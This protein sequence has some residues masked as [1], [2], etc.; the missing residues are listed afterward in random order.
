MKNRFMNLSLGI[1]C[2]V[3]ANQTTYADGLFDTDH[4]DQ[5]ILESL[6]DVK[7]DIVAREIKRICTE[8]YGN[9]WPVSREHRLYN[10][11]LMDYLEDVESEFAAIE[12]INACRK[13]FPE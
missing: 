11:C 10:E 1:L 6:Q 13:Q 12:I 5:C 3:F 2:L 7:L 9:R 4:Y 8:N